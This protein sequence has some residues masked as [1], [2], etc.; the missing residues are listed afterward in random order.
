MVGTHALP[1]LLKLSSLMKEKKAEWTQQDEL[2]VEIELA[3]N[4]R[5]HSIFACPVLKQVSSDENPPMIM[6]CGHVIC[7]EALMKLSKGNGYVNG[8]CFTCLLPNAHLHPAGVGSSVR[9]A[10]QSQFRLRRSACIF[11]SPINAKCTVS[12][13]T[14][15]CPRQWH[16]QKCQTT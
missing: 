13:A 4:Q 8:S 1:K 6:P 3:N 7:K 16:A 9:I 5:F 14:P 11:E 12:L 15:F 10:H 2:P